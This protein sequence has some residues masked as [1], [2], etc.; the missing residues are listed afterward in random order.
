VE[1]ASAPAASL[2][3]AEGWFLA[4]NFSY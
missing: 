4:R 3:R 1:S 2:G